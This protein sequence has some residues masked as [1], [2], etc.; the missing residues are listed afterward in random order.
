MLWAGREQIR[1]IKAKPR[2][3]SGFQVASA[4]LAR[5]QGAGRPCGPHGPGDELAAG[6]PDGLACF[7]RLLGVV[8]DLR[9]R[10]VLGFVPQPVPALGVG[11]V[12]G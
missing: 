8:T 4:P 1:Q 5:P 6:F 3:T 7:S 9:V 10:P 2:E 12:E 11:R